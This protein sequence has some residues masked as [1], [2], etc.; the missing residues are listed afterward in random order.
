MTI[1]NKI[2]ANKTPNKASADRS[3]DSQPVSPRM[4]IVGAGQSLLSRKRL[5][6]LAVLGGL[7]GTTLAVGVIALGSYKVVRGLILNS[8][9][10]QALLQVQQGS[11]EVDAWLSNRK[12]EV[13]MLANT[14]TVRSM[15][16]GSIEPYLKSEAARL[17]EFYQ[18]NWVAADGIG[19]NSRTGRTNI[20]LSDRQWFIEAMKGNSQVADPIFGRT[21]KRVV[22]VVSAPITARNARPVGVLAGLIGVDRIVEAVSQLKQ[23]AGSY[24]FALNSQGVAI[25]HP[26][27]KLIGTPEKP[28][29]SFLQSNNAPLR[30]IAQQMVSQQRGIELANIGG[31][32]QYIAYVPLKEA[33]WSIALVIPRQNI[34]SQ[35][36]ALNLLAC[37]LG[38]VLVIA[39]VGIWRQVQIHEQTRIHAA[40]EALLNRLTSRIRESLELQTIVQTTV[41][42]LAILTQLK[43]VLFGW[44]HPTAQWFEVVYESSSENS[45]Q[46]GQQLQVDPAVDL[47]TVLERGEA[48]ELHPLEALDSEGH[49]NLGQSSLK[50]QPD[51]YMALKMPTQE[52]GRIG[53][54]IGKNTS[55]LSREEREL[56]DAVAG[57]L[58]IAINQSRL[59][60]Q[61]QEQVVLVSQ[62]SQQLSQTL[63]ELQSAQS[64]LIQSEKMS[65]LG[66][67][68][69]GVA[70]EIN[71]PV[72]FIHG[73]LS[74]ASEYTEDL[75]NLLSLYQRHFPDVT[76][77]I[78]TQMEDVDL[79]F[80]KT[81]LPKLLN[82]MKIGTER[83]RGIVQSL[84]TFSRLDESDKKA[85]DV[86]EGIDSTLLILGHRFKSVPNK[87]TIEIV[88]AYG[89]LPKIDCYP[90]L[91]NQVFLNVITNAIDALEEMAEK[92]T[93]S[94][95]WQPQIVIRTE[96][97]TATW[98][99]VSI[100]DNGP[101][102]AQEVQQRLFDPFFTTKPVG[103][104]TGMGMSI[105]YQIVTEKHNG[106]LRC[107]STPGEGTEFA[108]EIPLQPVEQ[109]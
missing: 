21:A 87:R 94:Q 82:S 25:A 70:H 89:D 92:P 67:L 22:V 98:L 65:S 34:E 5:R 100:L 50:L 14:P 109:P 36:E 52:D 72:N 56:L 23:G 58:A 31:K 17:R 105:S 95:S 29:P 104:G 42:E 16:W 41:T 93:T 45:S 71:N 97:S 12:V 66:Q 55:T 83:I 49:P 24:A 9:K 15:D 51:F 7:L 61:T 62:Q 80:I 86:H 79:D 96:L 63:Q 47:A 19:F 85:V 32:W 30:S 107:H 103:K 81:D 28:A 60:T 106:F 43:R 20:S 77:D 54:L 57:Q 101:G 91:L 11:N 76:S 53:Y 40:Q 8:L 75:L 18:L 48:I 10:Q 102:M 38:S 78:Q 90:G 33:N 35:L 84:R 108:I 27:S 39:L 64:Q 46:L 4:G 73:N 74:H 37:V 68:V 13:E 44:Y 59:Y 2:V 88:K 6:S 26:D 69:A 1:V 3:Q 99:R